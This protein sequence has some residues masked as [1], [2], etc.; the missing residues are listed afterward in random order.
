[1]N[2]VFVIAEAGVNHDGDL[3][4]AIELIDVASDA[5]ADAVKFQTFK[6]EQL[7]SEGCPKA[8]YQQETT[9]SGE[10][11]FEMLKRLELR[12]SDHD[13]LIAHCK[14][15]RIEFMSS[16]FD[17][18]SV[19]ALAAKGLKRFK[20][21]SGEITNLMYLQAV[22]AVADE[23]ILSSG[24]AVM[25]EIEDA[26]RVIQ[27]IGFPRSSLTILHCTSDYPALH[28]D[29]NLRAMLS[30]RDKFDTRV[31]YSDH[32]VG[33]QIPLAAVAMGAEVIEKHFTLDKG[34]AG[35]DHRASLDPD[36]LKMMVASIRSLEIALG[37][38]IKK[39]C[40]VEVENAA[41]VRR[42]LV[43]SR[44]IKKGEVFS[45]ENLSAKRP[46]IGVSPMRLG[47]FIGKE[48]GRDFLKDELIDL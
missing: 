9:D 25:E 33:I 37:D 42:S 13:C 23:I 6:A 31:G 32:S 34:L 45:I 44:N 10:S 29:L 14:E 16:P 41:V 4:K 27:E 43:A 17:E 18:D 22:A 19:R 8:R 36:E 38:G 39:P 21:P 47:E 3:N 35:P 7:V 15:R 48:A 5:G 2:K 26:V 28:E 46:G 12:L 24:M 30:I 11:Q 40:S 20:I 1:M